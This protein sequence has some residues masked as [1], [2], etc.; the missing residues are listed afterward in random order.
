[1]VIYTINY[2]IFTF[3]NINGLIRNKRK[4]TYKGLY[5]QNQTVLTKSDIS[6]PLTVLEYKTWYDI[7]GKT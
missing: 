1:M 3:I 7:N 2:I 5:L 4:V 6:Q